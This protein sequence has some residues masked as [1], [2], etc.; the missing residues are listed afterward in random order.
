MRPHRRQ[1]V[2]VLVWRLPKLEVPFVMVPDQGRGLSFLCYV[3]KCTDRRGSRMVWWTA[4]PNRA[5]G[6]EDDDVRGGCWRG[7]ACMQGTPPVLSTKSIQLNRV[8]ALHAS[9]ALW[10]EIHAPQQ[11]VAQSNLRV[12]SR[13]QS[14]IVDRLDRRSPPPPRVAD[15]CC[16][17]APLIWTS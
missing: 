4:K 14:V 6:W 16:P 7:G 8:A 15:G 10:D 9:T 11:A 17:H 1:P 13:H 5:P 2:W 12:P 3:N